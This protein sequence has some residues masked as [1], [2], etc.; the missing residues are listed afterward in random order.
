MAATVDTSNIAIDSTGDTSIIVFDSRII[1]VWFRVRVS[2][3]MLDKIP[4]LRMSVNIDQGLHKA[5]ILSLFLGSISIIQGDPV[6]GTLLNPTGSPKK[7]TLLRGS[8]SSRVPLIL[9]PIC[10][11]G[12]L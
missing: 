8:I 9:T 2:R 4:S 5:G 12:T 6:K 7:G 1:A 11:H 3:Q 10:G